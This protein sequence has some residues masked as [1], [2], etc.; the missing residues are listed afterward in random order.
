MAHPTLRPGDR[1]GPYEI[2]AELGRGGAGVVVAARAVE[3]V[4]GPTHVAIKARLAA[5]GPGAARF[6]RE[7]GALRALRVPGTVRLHSAGQAGPIAWFSMDRVA[8]QDLRER[9]AAPADPAARG[10]LVARLAVTLLETLAGV[11][12]RGF[13]HRDLKPG[14]VLVDGTDRVWLLDFGVA[15]GWRSPTAALTRPGT[16]VGTLPYMAP[17]QVT[18]QVTGPEVDVFA[19]GL[20]LHEAIAGP[21]EPARLPQEWLARQCLERLVPL[22]VCA[23][24]TPPALSAAVCAML[25]FSPADRPTAAEAAALLRD[26]RPGGPAP[27]VRPDP[28]ELVGRDELVREITDAARAPSPTL[29][30]LEGPAGSGKRRTSEAA[31][32]R[33]LLR[34]MVGRRVQVHAHAPGSGLG[35]LLATLLE[36]RP[37]SAADAAVLSAVW[38]GLPGAPPPDGR[39]D[40]RAIAESAAR[41]I[42]DATAAAPLVVEV[43][44]AHDMHGL[45]AETLLVLARRAPP[46]LLVLLCVDDRWPGESW[47][48]LVRKAGPARLARHPLPDLDA[49]QATALAA[50]LGVP[51][52]ARPGSA[53]GATEAAWEA[54]A[55]R[56]QTPRTTL[57]WAL[58]PL[59]LLEVPVPDATVQALGVAPEAV[60]RLGLIRGSAAAGW[61]LADAA[62]R[63]L[64]WAGI[65]D[66]RAA[67]ARL[68]AALDGAA[69]GL[70]A[71]A[72][73]ASGG[74]ALDRAVHAAEHAMDHRLGGEARAWL[75]LADT[76]PRDRSPAA[77][78]GAFR[79]AAARARVSLGT[80]RGPARA[81]LVAQAE[82]RAGS[83]DEE[84]EAALLRAELRWRQG[85]RA[86][87]RTELD[88]VAGEA[89][90]SNPALAQHARARRAQ[91]ELDAGQPAAAHRACERARGV[92]GGLP[93]SLVEVDRRAAIW[94]G[95][96]SRAL[97]PPTSAVLQARGQLLLGRPSAARASLEP[98]WA[99][100]LRQGGAVR[101]E[102]HLLLARLELGDGRASVARAV[103]GG[104]QLPQDA[105]AWLPPDRDATALMLALAEG[106][107]SAGDRLAAEPPACLPPDWAP[108]A[109]RWWRLRGAPMQ[110]EPALQAAAARLPGPWG[111]AMADTLRAWL[112]LA[113]GRPEPAA[114]AAERARDGA[115]RAGLGG[116]GRQA[117]MLLA[118]ARGESDAAWSYLSARGARGRAALAQ[119]DA[120]EL[121]AIRRERRTDAEGAR[122]AWRR[123]AK[124]AGPAGWT[125]R[126]H[127]A[128]RMADRLERGTEPGGAPS[129][130]HLGDD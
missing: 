104:L 102:A 114:R 88:A 13:V 9:A 70:Q 22:V 95:E 56:T 79:R 121:D 7:I 23:P 65:A 54:L 86:M 83:P 63:T 5:D 60:A 62:V 15:R 68:L 106:D 28:P 42:Q 14:N 110:G 3:P 27:P 80:D 97:V 82:R 2:E 40:R 19:A 66:R 37:A 10:A 115:A 32:R 49:D 84:Q 43:R 76:L 6:Q 119:L 108:L 109:V 34:G 48:R 105:P 96:P 44:S 64:A 17:E 92:D 107:I 124:V 130:L 89:A 100:M 16:V 73:V 103:L 50:S 29:V 31:Q 125:M 72:A 30:S 39:A 35:D 47:L 52:A 81:D 118:A 99:A 91:L 93:T 71:I 33:L 20:L 51:G 4:A 24:G 55:R 11:H 126:A 101:T 127:H 90:R 58:L 128:R 41:I 25:R 94:T 74:G 129:T 122:L 21:R 87:A 67:G 75:L 36:D 38:P 112:A 77:R 69:P 120:L 116:L 59:A 12:Q 78:A 61:T 98:A 45:L 46:D 113:A 123:L 1:L 8:G 85:D 18:G 57:P 53:L 26:V 117:R 111:Q